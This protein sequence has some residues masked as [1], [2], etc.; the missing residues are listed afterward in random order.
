[1][2]FINVVQVL[3]IIGDVLVEFA[4]PL[5]AQFNFIHEIITCVKDEVSN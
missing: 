2:N 1:M 5:L 4:K 3:I